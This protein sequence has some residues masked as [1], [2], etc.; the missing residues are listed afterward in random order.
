MLPRLLPQAIPKHSLG[1]VIDTLRFTTTACKALEHAD[2]VEVASE[3]QEAFNLKTSQL[4]RD[5]LLLCGERHCKPIAGFDLG[6]SPLEYRPDRIAGK[7][8]VF[9]T[10]NGTRAVESLHSVSEIWLAALVNRNAV[11]Q[12]ISHAD[13]DH[14][15]IVCSGTEGVVSAEDCLAAG[16][17]LSG[18]STEFELDGNDSAMLCQQAFEHLGA[19]KEAP[20]GESL[21]RSLHHALR[22]AVGGKNLLEAGYEKDIAAASEIDSSAIV[23]KSQSGQKSLFKS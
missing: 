22:R 6:N 7:R 10:T 9:T 5:D 11:T 17:I 4:N 13:Y 8:L 19:S 21:D 2:S 3:V 12:A 16:A 18:L 14:L 1:I 23:P 15:T 20:K